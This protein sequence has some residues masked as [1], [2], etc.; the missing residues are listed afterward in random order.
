MNAQET[1]TSYVQLAN[2]AYALLV[3][4]VASSNQRTLEYG[5]SVWQITSRPYASTALES[6]VRENF[7]RANEILSLSVTALQANGQKAA[8]L[9]QKM[10]GYGTKLQDSVLQ[11]FRGL[12]NTG[13]SNVNY[14]K[15]TATQHFGDLAKRLDEIQ[16]R[17]AVP[18]SNN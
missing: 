9:G 11:A 2:E 12:V 17:S 1:T 5:K 14:A 3:D 8:E 13:I 18:A 4:A 15:E 10:F 6:T 7:D 16:T